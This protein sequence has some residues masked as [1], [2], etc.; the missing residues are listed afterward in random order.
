VLYLHLARHQQRKYFDV[1]GRLLP[2]DLLNCLLAALAEMQQQRLH[3]LLIEQVT[4]AVPVAV[5]VA[6]RLV[7][8]VRLSSCRAMSGT[9]MSPLVNRCG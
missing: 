9:L 6:S 5:G 8:L 7:L 1:H 4:R 3:E 2:R